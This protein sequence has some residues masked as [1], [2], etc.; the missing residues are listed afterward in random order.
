MSHHGSEQS[1]GGVYLLFAH[2]ACYPPPGQEINT[3]L[4]DAATLLHPR[5]RQPD[6]AR[7]HER[8]T[9]GRRPGEIVPLAMLAHELEGGRLWPQVGDWQAATADL[10]QLI[11]DHACDA[12]AYARQIGDLEAL[13][14]LLARLTQPCDA[15]TTDPTKGEDD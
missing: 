15:R 10:L 12:I 7:I 5:V 4:V 14:L 2:E 8:L 11:H 1:T 9:R 3:S 6:G 13:P